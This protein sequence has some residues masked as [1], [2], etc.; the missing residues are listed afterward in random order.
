MLCG[1]LAKRLSGEKELSKVFER[2]EHDE[3]PHEA[4]FMEL[5]DDPPGPRAAAVEV[6][7]PA[8]P[9]WP[10]RPPTLRLKTV[11]CGPSAGRCARGGRR[12]R[13]RS[14]DTPAGTLAE[15][16]KLPADPDRP[17]PSQARLSRAARR[18][19]G[20]LG[21]AHH[22]VRWSRAGVLRLFDGRIDRRRRRS[23][24]FAR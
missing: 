6:A 8:R 4:R 1:R 14:A 10:R 17:R 21:G 2:L 12:V 19:R 22:V 20:A 15:I 18:V 23:K 3:R 7:E 11:G 9:V 16:A 5:L 24:R 13:R